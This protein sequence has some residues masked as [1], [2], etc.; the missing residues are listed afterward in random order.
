MEP[1][2]A[3][4]SLLA[5]DPAA[6]EAFVASTRPLLERAARSVVG[7][8]EAAE[9]VVQ[10]VYAH[11]CEDG[12]RA[13]REFRGESRVTT[14]L[15]SIA[16]RQGRMFVRGETRR[17]AREA[18]AAGDGEVDPV[19]GAVG[20]EIREAL[21]AARERLAPRDRLLLTLAHEDGRTHA[22]IATVLGVSANSVGPLLARAR[23]RLGK[24]LDSMGVRPGDSTA[25]DGREA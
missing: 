9:E 14:W 4:S 12:F 22:E 6:W 20:S 25:T 8:P 19:D 23:A 10:A 24:N 15:A 5:G 2:R 11:L 18:V 1:E 3:F 13:L 7:S 21:A 16:V 17:K